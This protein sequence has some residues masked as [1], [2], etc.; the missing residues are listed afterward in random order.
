MLGVKVIKGLERGTVAT[1]S[2]VMRRDQ[3]KGKLGRLQGLDVFRV[4]PKAPLTAFGF[5][6]S[7][8]RADG[9][10]WL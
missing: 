3:P 7:C 1:A 9:V 6:A 10:R 5:S 8:F 2:P 4:H